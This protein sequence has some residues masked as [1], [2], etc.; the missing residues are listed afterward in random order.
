MKKIFVSILFLMGI[1]SLSQNKS[2][3]FIKILEE[4]KMAHLLYSQFYDLYQTRPFEMIRLSEIRHF[5]SLKSK[6]LN[7]DI[8]C[9]SIVLDDETFQNNEIKA[10]YNKFKAQGKSSE[11][12]ALKIG[13]WI[14]EEDIKELEKIIEVATNELK[15]VLQQ[16]IY[17]SQNHLEAFN[18]H[19]NN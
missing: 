1:F 4:E 6:L 16:L 17:A 15:P 12:D 18:K 3:Q 13:K 14:E 11:Q 10:L 7:Q 19:I 2:E 5:N 9:E 8:P